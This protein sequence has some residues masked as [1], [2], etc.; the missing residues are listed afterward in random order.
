M[1]FMFLI[2]N[3]T[4]HLDPFLTRMDNIDKNGSVQKDGIKKTVN[5]KRKSDAF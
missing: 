2:T 5:V 3:H 4:I 1:I